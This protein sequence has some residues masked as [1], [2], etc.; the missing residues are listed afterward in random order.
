MRYKKLMRTGARISG[1]IVVLGG[2]IL[3][4][5]APVIGETLFRSLWGVEPLAYIGAI[6]LVVG[7]G[8][9]A[10]FYLIP[11]LMARRKGQPPAEGSFEQGRTGRLRTPV[12]V[13]AEPPGPAGLPRRRSGCGRV[14]LP[15]VEPSGAA[16]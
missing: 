14:A 12:R 4:I 2:I 16:P 13:R 11:E 6:L 3:L 5:L 1:G 8:T 9:L 15:A 7:L 10:A